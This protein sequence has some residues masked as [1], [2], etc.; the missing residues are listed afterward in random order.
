MTVTSK[1]L[2]IIADDLSGA[3][4][5][6][7]VCRRMGHESVVLT[8][9][10]ESNQPG[11]AQASVIVVVTDSRHLPSI[12]ASHRLDAA[13]RWLM[14][15]GIYSFYKKTDSAARGPLAAELAALA[16]VEP[17]CAVYFVPAFPRL[18]R[19]VT[20]G[21]LYINGVPVAETAF[22]KDPRSPI[23]TSSLLTLLRQQTD[24]PVTQANGKREAS[25]TLVLCD[26]TTDDDV[27]TSV[28]TAQRR[29]ARLAGPAGALEALLPHLDLDVSQP[30]ESRMDRSSVLIV[31]G[32]CHPVTQAQINHAESAG[33]CVIHLVPPCSM[34]N[35]P[36][37]DSSNTFITMTQD[38]WRQHRPVILC[39]ARRPVDVAVA[40]AAGR[41]Q[42]LDIH[43]YTE[44]I[45]QY[46]VATTAR[47]LHTLHPSL[48][49][50]CG[51]ATSQAMIDALGID[52]LT[53]LREIEPGIGLCRAHTGHMLAIKNG[54]FGKVDAL[55]NLFARTTG[56]ITGR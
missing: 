21:I 39:T 24:V 13:A 22:A 19:T 3:I 56:L 18:G 23:H 8:S 12:T 27:H 5:C 4:E 17:T 16:R 40:L 38:A 35:H 46:L 44:Q 11:Q 2:G 43:V 53:L 42:G 28:N 7:A 36:L 1:Q 32:S 48:I 41:Q 37:P 26:G 34:E 47:L 52:R 49:T 50:V 25:A 9:I 30:L 20:D 45:T 33:A 54:A 55:T 31:A 29:G 6:A 14:R 15:Q 10:P 51:G